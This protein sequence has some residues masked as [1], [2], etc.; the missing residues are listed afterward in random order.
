M[1]RGVQMLG[2]PRDYDLEC[3]RLEAECMQLAAA[4]NDRKSQSH[5]LRMAQIWSTMAVQGEAN[6]P[7]GSDYGTD[8]RLRVV[9]TT[10]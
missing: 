5:F 1:R 10:V 2:H 3:L 7:P 9:P 4:V 8:A 6:I